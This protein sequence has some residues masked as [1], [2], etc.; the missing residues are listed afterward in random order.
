[1]KILDRTGGIIEYEIRSWNKRESFPCRKGLVQCKFCATEFRVDL[2]YFDAVG[3]VILFTRWKN[4]GE[5]RS[6]LDH[7]WRSHLVG[8][9]GSTCE[10]VYFPAGSICAAFEGAGEAFE[11]DSLM[12]PEFRKELE[13]LLSWRLPI[14]VS[15]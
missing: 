9:G 1:V 7:Q 3:R 2:E 4:L 8:P 13:V 12:T 6:P 10:R 14:N 5:G 15:Y 11:I